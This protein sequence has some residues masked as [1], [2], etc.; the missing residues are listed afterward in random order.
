MTA[1]RAVHRSSINQVD[2]QAAESVPG[3]R[4][5]QRNSQQ[6]KEREVI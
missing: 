5:E 3:V 2:H 4:M 6:N 1:A